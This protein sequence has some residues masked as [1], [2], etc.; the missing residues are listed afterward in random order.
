[1]KVS[2]KVEGFAAIEAAVS[3]ENAK[4][5]IDCAIA[6]LKEERETLGM[7][8]IKPDVSCGTY[9]GMLVIQCSHCGKYVSL[10][11]KKPIDIYKCECGHTTELGQMRKAVARC[12]CGKIWNM[13]TNIQ[14]DGFE[15]KC[16]SCGTPIDLE[17]NRKT[18][19]YGNIR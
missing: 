15:F 12:E 14:R 18:N 1:M 6:I 19:E 16:L 5:L 13:K 7:R 10:S 3:E 4:K 17:L 9:S 2:V 8:E 11:T